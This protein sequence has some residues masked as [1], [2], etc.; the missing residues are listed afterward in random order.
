MVCVCIYHDY[1]QIFYDLSLNDACKILFLMQQNLLAAQ[2]DAQTGWC[3]RR[4]TDCYIKSRAGEK[5]DREIINL[6]FAALI[7]LIDFDSGRGFFPRWNA[8][9]YA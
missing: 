9:R 4:A 5:V 8:L 2:S 3:S 6:L 1:N 7:Y